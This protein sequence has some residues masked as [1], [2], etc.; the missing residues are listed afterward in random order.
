MFVISIFHRFDFQKLKGW[1]II[2][3]MCIL[4]H[5]AF[6]NN[7]ILQKGG[8]SCHISPPPPFKKKYLDQTIISMTLSD[9]FL[10]TVD[11]NLQ[12]KNG[13]LLPHFF[14]KSNHKVRATKS[15][16]KHYNTCR[17]NVRYGHANTDCHTKTAYITYIHNIILMFI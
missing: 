7:N 5:S 11:I 4:Q 12:I 1:H 16:W 3:F 6:I 14:V 2:L 9:T 8:W 10:A 15:W 17:I 13:C